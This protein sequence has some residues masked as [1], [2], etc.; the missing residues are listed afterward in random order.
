MMGKFLKSNLAVLPGA[1]LIYEVQRIGEN[2][3]LTS[4]SYP[5]SNLSYICDEF[6]CGFIVLIVLA[7]KHCSCDPLE[8]LKV[9]PF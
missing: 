4:G 3:S 5:V 7:V 8:A 6:G 1:K 2:K 9:I